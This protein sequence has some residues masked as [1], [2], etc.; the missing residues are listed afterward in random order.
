MAVTPNYSWPVPVDTDL[1]KDG[2]EAIKDLGDAIDATVFGLP[3]GALALVKTQVIGSAVSSVTVSSAFSATYDAYKIV[4][5]GGV[6]SGSDILALTFPGITTG[7]YWSG[8]KVTFANS[9][10]TGSGANVGSFQQV[11][12]VTVNSLNCS[13]ELI[14]PFLTKNTHIRA[15]F[16]AAVTS[17][18]SM[19]VGG[20]LNNATSITGFTL[21]PPNGTLTGG[22]IRVYGYQN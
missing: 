21:T 19:S 11:G 22:T 17:G 3:S 7:Y 15:S 18:D 14:N 13:L 20:Y 12:Y 5:T 6:A 9:S 2:A 16:I 10:G 8:Q 1:V 4:V